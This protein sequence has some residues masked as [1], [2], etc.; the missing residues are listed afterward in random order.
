MVELGLFC[1]L[2]TSNH[3]TNA[4]STKK[5]MYV[6]AVCSVLYSIRV[7]KEHFE[8]YGWFSCAIFLC[9]LFWLLPFHF[10]CFRLRV[11]SVTLYTLH[12]T[13]FTCV[14]APVFFLDHISFSSSS[15]SA[16]PYLFAIFCS[17]CIKVK[18]HTHSYSHESEKKNAII[19]Y[20]RFVTTVRVHI[21]HNDLTVGIAV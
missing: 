18:F 9:G 12:S 7:S 10:F 13:L 19:W 21:I 16:I 14:S 2:D 5:W 17:L 20:T 4:A 11:H 1:A 6:Y 8:W 3:I 15:S